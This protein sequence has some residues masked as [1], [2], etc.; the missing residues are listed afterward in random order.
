MIRHNLCYSTLIKPNELHK[1]NID[2][3]TKTPKGDYFIKSNIR[4]GILPIILENLLN[5]RK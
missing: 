3:Y 5:A 4:K 2:D 1:Y